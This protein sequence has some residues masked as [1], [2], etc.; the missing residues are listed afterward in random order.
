MIDIENYCHVIWDW[1]GT[2]IDDR[3]VNVSIVNSLLKQR[4]LPEI[5]EKEYLASFGFPVIDFYRQL[6]FN[7]EKESF[8]DISNEYFSMYVSMEEHC[9]LHFETMKLVNWFSSKSIPQSILSAYEQS[10]LQAV[11]K[12]KKVETTFSNI[13]GSSNNSGHGKLTYGRIL[14]EKIGCNYKEVLLI[15]D[16]LHDYE[17]AS[18]MGIDCLL[19]SGGHQSIDR[20]TSCDARVFTVA[21][22]VVPELATI[23]T[24]RA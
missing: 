16:T 13:L 15:G 23:R 19:F 7:L 24:S 4:S 22:E 10:R 9:N 12:K 8:A 14:M 6:G 5:N 2:L 21:A 20:F 11:I 1:N 18:H 17:T 3:A